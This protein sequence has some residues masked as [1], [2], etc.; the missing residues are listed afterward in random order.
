MSN[1]FMVELSK[2]LSKYNAKIMIRTEDTIGIDIDNQELILCDCE[3]NAE[4]VVND[5]KVFECEKK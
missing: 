3:I 1:D 2:L 4:N 5:E